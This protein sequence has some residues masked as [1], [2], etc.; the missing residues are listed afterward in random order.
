MVFS[1]NN[2]IERSE[3]KKLKH[4]KILA[5]TNQDYRIRF[6]AESKDADSQSPNYTEMKKRLKI[7]KEKRALKVDKRRAHKFETKVQEALNKLGK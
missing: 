6:T 3:I 2:A 7:Q 5:K 4:C 1:W